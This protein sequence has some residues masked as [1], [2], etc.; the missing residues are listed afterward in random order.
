MHA[1]Y[2][3][4]PFVKMKRTTQEEKTK[5]I[6]LVSH[7]LNKLSLCDF[8]YANGA[9]DSKWKSVANNFNLQW[10]LFTASNGVM[11]HE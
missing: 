9:C 5:I 6:T 1:D 2:N 7:Y 3:Q 10:R 8:K 11:P 4:T